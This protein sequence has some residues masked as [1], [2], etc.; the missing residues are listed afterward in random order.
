[1]TRINPFPI[2]QIDPN[3][4]NTPNAE[5]TQASEAIEELGQLSNDQALVRGFNFVL[6][7][8]LN[9]DFTEESQLTALINPSNILLGGVNYVLNNRSKLESSRTGAGVRFTDLNGGKLPRKALPLLMKLIEERS[10]SAIA[11]NTSTSEIKGFNFALQGVLNGDF[12]E[13]SQLTALINPSNI[14]LGGVNYVLNNRSKLESSRTG[15]GV[16]FTDLNGGKLPRKALPLLMKL[17][18]ERS[19]SAIAL[20]TSTSEIK[21]FNFALQGVLNGDFTEESQLTAL[22]NPSNILL[23]GVNYV[24]NNRSKLENSRTGAGV[25]FTSLN[26]GKLSRNDCTNLIKIINLLKN[27]SI[28]DELKANL[29]AYLETQ[30]PDSLKRLQRVM[31]MSSDDDTQAEVCKLVDDLTLSLK[32]RKLRQN[33]YQIITSGQDLS[34]ALQTIS[35]YEGAEVSDVQLKADLKDAVLARKKRDLVVQANQVISQA[36]TDDTTIQSLLDKIDPLLKSSETS[37]REA[38]LELTRLV[39]QLE[40]SELRSSLFTKITQGNFD[41]TDPNTNKSNIDID[42][43]LESIAQAPIRASIPG[44]DYTMAVKNIKDTALAIAKDLNT[45]RDFENATQL[46]EE[47]PNTDFDAVINII[48]SLPTDTINRL[49]IRK[50]LTQLVRSFVA[51]DRPDDFDAR[52]AP[53]IDQA[54]QTRLEERFCHQNSA[55]ISQHGIMSGTGS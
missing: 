4:A 42:A 52:I 43:L 10:S 5:T 25:R 34:D 24:L 46:R 33:V 13:E 27:S 14:L 23:G 1:M 54:E 12:T 47:F 6:E 26:G 28:K 16:R 17:I 11:L 38:G 18:E 50:Q 51:T 49:E 29:Q 19:S 44:L 37:T 31:S 22:I 30:N 48:N 39:Y 45:F 8:V 35:A 2:K 40:L 21:G 41:T 36:L 9:G 15:A 32:Q 55:I 7:G 20:N 3:N 53:E